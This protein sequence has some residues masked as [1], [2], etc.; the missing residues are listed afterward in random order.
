MTGVQ[1]CALPICLTFGANTTIDLPTS[2]QAQFWGRIARWNIGGNMA[3]M[4]EGVGP[5]NLLLV[6]SASFRKD[7]GEVNPSVSPTSASGFTQATCRSSNQT[8]AGNCLTDLAPLNFAFIYGGSMRYFLGSFSI[9]LG[10]T[11]L[12]NFN[13]DLGDSDLEGTLEAGVPASE[14]GRGRWVTDAPPHTLLMFTSLGATYVVNKY[15]N[16][17]ASLSSFQ[18]PI[19]YI[20]DNPRGLVFPF[21]DSAERSFTNANLSASFM[22]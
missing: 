15:L 20:G 17:T 3:E 14:V 10:V 22:Y 16:V 4:L 1:T 12:S 21:F 7:I 11:F 5:G 18:S 19:R 6:L 9:G 13:H 8:D 2:E